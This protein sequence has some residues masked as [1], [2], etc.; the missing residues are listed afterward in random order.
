MEM[1]RQIFMFNSNN[2]IE[3]VSND[4]GILF[5]GIKNILTEYIGDCIIENAKAGDINQV[6][7]W[8]IQMEHVTNCIHLNEMIELAKNN[9]FYFKDNEQLDYKINLRGALKDE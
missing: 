1:R 8:A 3:L 2:E 7:L 6:Q 9:H 4:E 5:L